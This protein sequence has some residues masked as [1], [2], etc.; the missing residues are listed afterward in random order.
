MLPHEFPQP[1]RVISADPPWKFDDKLPGDGVRGAEK[2]YDCLSLEDI[3]KFPLPPL[4]EDAILFLWRVSAMPQ[5]ALDVVKAWGFT[6]KSEL[7]WTKRTKKDKLAIGMGRYVRGAHETCLIATRGSFS[8]HVVD[9]GI[10]SVL[11]YPLELEAPIGEHSEK[12]DAFYELIEQLVGGTEHGPLVELFGRKPRANWHV[13]GNELP[14]GYAGSIE[15]PDA[16]VTNGVGIHEPTTNTVGVQPLVVHRGWD[17]ELLRIVARD[18]I[19]ET[20]LTESLLKIWKKAAA[21]ESKNEPAA[22]ANAAIPEHVPQELGEHPALVSPSDKYKYVEAAMKE[23]W[24]KSDNAEPLE[25]AWIRLLYSV[26]VG[27]FKRVG[28]GESAPEAPQNGASNGHHIVAHNPME[29]LSDLVQGIKKAGIECT[30]IDV[31]SWSVNDRGRAFAWLDGG[32][33]MKNVP[34]IIGQ[35]FKKQMVKETGNP[36]IAIMNSGCA[37]CEAGKPF[38]K[39]TAYLHTGEGPRCR[40]EAES[41]PP[42][43]GGRGR[44]PKSAKVWEAAYASAKIELDEE[45]NTDLENFGPV[46]N[47]AI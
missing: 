29:N 16:V 17:P 7:V 18:Y 40:E 25:E 20:P 13:F 28:S 45:A 39:E 30:L 23:G 43:K 47:A 8:K 32:A 42:K 35:L 26:P 33:D 19:E 41:N 5:E 37:G 21:V 11:E 36:N 12:P 44:K 22:V 1:V 38:T 34:E 3:K 6:I 24:F 4:A 15:V 9:K 2:K 46:S 31:T 14:F 10:R 27:F